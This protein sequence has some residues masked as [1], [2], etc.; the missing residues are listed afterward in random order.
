MPSTLDIRPMGFDERRVVAALLAR[1]GFRYRGT[2]VL[3]SAEG[4]IEVDRIELV[5]VAGSE[6]LGCAGL[7]GLADANHRTKCIHMGTLLEF[8]G[9]GVADAMLEALVAASRR[10][11]AI[12]DHLELTV[13][14]T[15]GT[16][17]QPPAA[18]GL[19]H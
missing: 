13:Y 14:F 2:A 18:L 4:A 7:F 16:C 17:R 15:D 9:R 11:R 8:R 5:A 6:M 3:R 19:I 10:S 1:P 12:L